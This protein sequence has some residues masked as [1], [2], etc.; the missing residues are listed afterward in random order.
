MGLSR[1]LADLEEILDSLYETLG[2]A[3]KHYVRASDIFIK[4]SIKQRIRKELL[5]EIHEY[6]A[7]YWKLLAQ[8]G[9]ACE[10]N[11][12][13]AQSVIIQVEPEVV[14]LIESRPNG[15]YSNELMQKL[16]EILNKLNEPGNPAAAKAKLALNLIPGILS[17]EVEVDTEQALRNAF[18]PIRNLFREALE[19]RKAH[20][21]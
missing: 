7:E 4:N 2:E 15:D 5:P 19:N 12:V 3:Q 1:R 20:P 11:E 21:N 6:E 14:Q 10:V 16:Q 13:K 17:Y 8:V 9:L 18:Q